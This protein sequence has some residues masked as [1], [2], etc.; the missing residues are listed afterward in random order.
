MIEIMSDDI[1]E[2]KLTK[3]HRTQLKSQN[4]SPL[5]TIEFKDWRGKITQPNLP[6]LVEMNSFVSFQLFLFY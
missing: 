6:E 5:K 4:S 3:I 2:E 1:N